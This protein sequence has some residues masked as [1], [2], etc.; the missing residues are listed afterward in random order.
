MNLVQSIVE[1][2][3]Q[4]PPFPTV[5]QRALQLLDSPK[6]SVQS[7]VEVIQYDQ[8]ITANVLRVCNSAF[9]SL[10]SPV[11]SLRDALV[12]IGFNQVLEIILSR[13]IG[14][15]IAKDY[16]GYDLAEGQLWRHSVTCALLSQIIAE[17]LHEPPSPTHFTAALLHDIGK[18]ILSKFVKDRIEEIRK[19]VLE[20]NLSFLEAEKRTLGLDHAEL[21]GKIAEHWEFP[22]VIVSAIRFHHTPLEASEDPEISKRI[23]L[24]DMVAI[25]TGI[26]GGADGLS[27]HAHKEVMEE[28]QLK[29]KD[30]EHFIVELDRRY[31]EVEVLMNAV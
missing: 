6:S 27:Y 31:K 30:I 15:F 11:H 29:E 24:C 2:S 26:G 3:Y 1:S 13:G 8:A 25:L 14:H 5:L 16:P 17:R 10:R 23:Y 28:Y 9:F 7:L 20:E 21:G 19:I 4:L 18:V 22:R 12:R